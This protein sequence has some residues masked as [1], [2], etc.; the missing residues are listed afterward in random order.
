[1]L[2]R[3]KTVLDE[4]VAIN[5]DY[6]VSVE[7]IPVG[8]FVDVQGRGTATIDRPACRLNFQKSYF[9]VWGCLESV[10]HALQTGVDI[11]GCPCLMNSKNDANCPFVLE[12][13]MATQ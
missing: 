13:L 4:V 5:G 6:I 9:M 3:M 10:V 1:M 12:N 2:I 8:S 7:Y 11:L